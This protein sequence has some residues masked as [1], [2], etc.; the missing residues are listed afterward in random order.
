MFRETH[1]RSVVKTITW[2]VLATLT[3]FLLVYFFTG[4]LELALTVGFLEAILKM[5][6]YFLHERGWDKIKFGRRVITPFVIWF[7]GLSGSG[8]TDLAT[9]TYEKLKAMGLKIDRLDGH[10]V[11]NIFPETGFSR[12]EVNKHISR[13]GYLASKLENNGVIVVASFLSPYAESRNK[14][15]ELCTNFIEIFIDTPLEACK[16]NDI[17]GIYSRYEQGEI[18]NLPGLDAPYD[19]PENPDLILRPDQQSEEDMLKKITHL[20][21]GYI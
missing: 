14:I 7:T 6:I 4:K 16:K 12:E 8:K 10:V 2:R 3:T 21:K 19:R 5:V 9:A 11:R 13:V 18:I 17:D 1:S 20:F 15:R